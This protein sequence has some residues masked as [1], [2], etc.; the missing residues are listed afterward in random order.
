[1]SVHFRQC[2]SVSFEFSPVFFNIVILGSLEEKA[3]KLKSV[4]L[5]MW[6]D[7][8]K[9]LVKIQTGS[10]ANFICY[11][12]MYFITL[13]LDHVAQRSHGVKVQCKTYTR[14][15]FHP[16]IFISFPTLK[17]THTQMCPKQLTLMLFS[18]NNI[19]NPHTST[20]YFLKRK[21]W[22]IRIFK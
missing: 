5:S 9:L 18:R 14:R 10:F 6:S 1:M 11:Q 12:Q 3:Q 21:K 20:N 8:I 2:I 15:N 16:G 19:S 13:S 7:S 22:I 4:L 17:Y